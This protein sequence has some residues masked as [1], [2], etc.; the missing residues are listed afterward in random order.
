MLLDFNIENNRL[1][2]NIKDNG[3]GIEKATKINQ[4]NTSK[5]TSFAT[6]AT[7]E[8]LEI[9]NR[10]ECE[11]SVETNEILD[12]NKQSLGTEVKITME[13]RYEL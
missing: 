10:N 11:I 13:I 7:L 4:K 12:T 2:I 1:K 9:I 3:I 8:R 5:N 6:K